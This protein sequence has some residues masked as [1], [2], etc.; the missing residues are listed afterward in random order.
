MSIFVKIACYF[1][2]K[3]QMWLKSDQKNWFLK[4]FHL[5]VKTKTYNFFLGFEDSQFAKSDVE[6]WGLVTAILLF[7]NYHVNSSSKCSSVDFI[8]PI[9]DSREQRSCKTH[10]LS[11]N[12]TISQLRGHHTTNSKFDLEEVNTLK[13]WN[14]NSNWQW[15]HG[16]TSSRSARWRGRCRRTW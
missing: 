9:L 12:H 10:F 13:V 14:L 8:I 6:R 7:N 4:K 3:I 5:Y 15:W 11:S 2:R 1:G 16:L